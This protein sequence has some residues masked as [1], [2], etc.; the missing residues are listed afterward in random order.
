MHLTFIPLRFVKV[1]D[2]NVAEISFVMVKKEK[3]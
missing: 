2:F 1:G 3:P